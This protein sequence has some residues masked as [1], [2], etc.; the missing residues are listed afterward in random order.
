MKTLTLLALAGLLCGCG[1]KHGCD[2]SCIHPGDK[3]V[4]KIDGRSGVVV[5]STPWAVYVR[6]VNTNELAQSPYVQVEM[7]PHELEKR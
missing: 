3:V 5:H 1:E 4:A 7:Q 2:P 6:F